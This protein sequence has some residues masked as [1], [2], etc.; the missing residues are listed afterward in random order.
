MATATN[1]HPAVPAEEHKNGNIAPSSDSKDE[2]QTSRCVDET[3]HPV[4]EHAWPRNL[5][6]VG[7]HSA[8]PLNEFAA[9]MGSESFMPVSMDK[10]CEKA[11][12]ILRS[13]CSKYPRYGGPLHWRL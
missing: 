6:N 10:E 5:Q 3:G 11:A 13:F 8:E 12:R 4:P 2:P 7:M 1:G 9:K